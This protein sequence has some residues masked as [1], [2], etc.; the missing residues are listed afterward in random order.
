MLDTI[1]PNTVTLDTI[2]SDAKQSA[3]RCLKEACSK[4]RGEWSPRERHQRQ[5]R[6][7]AM[8]QQLWALVHGRER[9]QAFAIVR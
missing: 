9:A 2:T 8:Q 5:Q 6:A 3:S 7:D 1:T 4:V